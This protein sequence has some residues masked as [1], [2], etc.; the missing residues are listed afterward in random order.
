M[1]LL[2]ERKQIPRI[3]GTIRNSRKAIDH[4]EPIS[5]PWAQGV[6]RSNRPAPTT[7]ISRPAGFVC[8]CQVQI[9]CR[10]DGDDLI[11]G[12]RI[13]SPKPTADMLG[14]PTLRQ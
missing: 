14:E 9:K 5:L 13:R 6:G 10:L 12:R 1:N 3:V 11:A 2:V 7:R 8:R 4:L